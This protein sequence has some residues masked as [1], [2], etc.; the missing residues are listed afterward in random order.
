MKRVSKESS[1]EVKAP[2][3]VH[4]RIILSHVGSLNPTCGF[5]KLTDGR[6]SAT[7][8]KKKLKSGGQHA[9]ILER[10]GKVAIFTPPQKFKTGH[11]TTVSS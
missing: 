10:A 7:Q 6:Y 2:R 11:C 8:K 3:I 5:E 4:E 1:N 9:H